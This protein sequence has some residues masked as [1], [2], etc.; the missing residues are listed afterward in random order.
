[1][2]PGVYWATK[3]SAISERRG[4]EGKGETGKSW[5]LALK[6]S[7]FGTSWNSANLFSSYG[8]IGPLREKCEYFG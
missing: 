1:M 6:S 2:A 4:K 3:Q 8:E 7:I 5:R